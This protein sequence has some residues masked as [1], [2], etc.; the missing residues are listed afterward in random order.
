[1]LAV[2]GT[3]V[4]DASSIHAEVLSEKRALEEDLAT[5]PTAGAFASAPRQQRGVFFG[6]Q[7]CLK[8]AAELARRLL[9]TKLESA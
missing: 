2:D 1:M 6:M 7:V 9:R 8:K 5:C 4:E 3:A